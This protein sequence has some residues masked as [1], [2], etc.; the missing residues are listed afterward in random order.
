MTVLKGWYIVFLCNSYVEKHTVGFQN[1]ILPSSLITV[2]INI[3][4][5]LGQI[6]NF[7]ER[8]S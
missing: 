2:H 3:Q 4:D 8:G 1:S 7:S 6:Q 5:S